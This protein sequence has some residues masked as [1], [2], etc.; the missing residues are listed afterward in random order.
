MA[1]LHEDVTEAIIGGAIRV[2][3]ELGP[4]LMESAYEHCLAYELV[5]QG[6]DVVRQVPLPV[7]YRDV[8][9]D[10]GYRMDMVVNEVVI[11][12]LKCVDKVLQLH[13][14]Q[15]MTYLRL[16]GKRVGLLINFNVA[17]LIKGVTRR[18]I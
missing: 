3:T 13:E 15:I 6:L 10:C 2:H 8:Q 11:L 7:R 9:L 12:E 16:S 1:L 18:V 4:G 5:S 17:Q 14:S